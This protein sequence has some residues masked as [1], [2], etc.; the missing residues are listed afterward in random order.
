M[1][2]WFHQQATSL[3]LCVVLFGALAPAISHSLASATGSTWVEICSVTG[4]KR[5]ML[6][7]GS[8]LAP[9]VC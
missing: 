9:A 3:A 5:M 2:K 4:P 8:P 6:D 1:R 7:T